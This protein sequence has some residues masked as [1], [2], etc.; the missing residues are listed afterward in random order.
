LEEKL[1]SNIALEDIHR[2][3]STGYVMNCIKIYEPG[4]IQL[5]S[6]SWLTAA[7]ERDQKSHVMRFYCGFGR[8]TFFLVVQTALE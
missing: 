8:F 6:L 1:L 7:G 5:G 4:T 2:I 3:F